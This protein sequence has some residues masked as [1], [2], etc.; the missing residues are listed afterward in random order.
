M[1]RLQGGGREGCGD[2]GLG[3]WDVLVWF[4]GRGL[5]RRGVAGKERGEE[6]L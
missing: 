6:G 2:K 1:R 4:D 5:P 3:V